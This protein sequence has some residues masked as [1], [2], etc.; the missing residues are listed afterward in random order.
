M[1]LFD[2]GPEPSVI[3]MKIGS[4]RGSKGFKNAMKGKIPFEVKSKGGPKDFKIGKGILL[5][6]SSK[7]VRRPKP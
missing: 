4:V 5:E 7:S 1:V 2:K 6:K 3:T